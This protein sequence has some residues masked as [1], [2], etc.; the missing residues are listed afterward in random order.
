LSIVIPENA[1]TDDSEI[2]VKRGQGRRGL[3]GNSSCGSGGGTGR[4]GW[5]EDDERPAKRLAPS[6]LN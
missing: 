6:Q 5:G 1:F 4:N 2:A 3:S